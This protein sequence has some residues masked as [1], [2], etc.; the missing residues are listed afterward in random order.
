MPLDRLLVYRAFF[1]DQVVNLGAN[2]FTLQ[3]TVNW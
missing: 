2:V 3:L 1:Q